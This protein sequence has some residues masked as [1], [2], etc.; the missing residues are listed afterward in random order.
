MYKIRT[1]LCMLS[2]L[3][4]LFF[5]CL[6]SCLLMVSLQGLLKCYILL[7]PYLPSRFNAFGSELW[8]EGGHSGSVRVIAYCSNGQPSW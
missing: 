3:L 7:I 6:L 5:C 8:K 1:W 2:Y 4:P